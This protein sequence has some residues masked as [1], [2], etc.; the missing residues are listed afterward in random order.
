MLA[1]VGKSTIKLQHIDSH[2]VVK[3][4]HFLHTSQCGNDVFVF[5]PAQEF[6]ERCHALSLTYNNEILIILLPGEKRLT[7]P[8]LA[9]GR[10]L[11]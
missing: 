3:C 6:L 8:H 10:L 7:Q 4:Y 2:E 11:R 5:V 1:K 9:Q